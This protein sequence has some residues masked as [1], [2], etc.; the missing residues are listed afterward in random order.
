MPAIQA[1]NTAVRAK[2]LESPYVTENDVAAGSD[3]STC[4]SK[5]RGKY[6][7]FMQKEQ[8]KYGR[9]AAEYG[10]TPTIRYFAKVDKQECTLSPSTIFAWK[11][12]YLKELAKRKHDEL[13]EVEVLLPKKCGG[14]FLI[15]VQLDDRVKLYVKE[16]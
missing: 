11:E 8:A 2:L 9:R 6:Q 14:Q 1:A 4:T 16:M 12:N 7:F 15:G 3:S 13:T 10:I 5:R